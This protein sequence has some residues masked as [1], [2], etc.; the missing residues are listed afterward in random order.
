QT[1]RR[2]GLTMQEIES[3]KYFA[4]VESQTVFYFMEVAKL[5]VSRDPE[6]LTFFTMW[7]YEEYFHS[8]ALTPLLV[9]CGVKVESAT[10]RSLRIRAG[11]R[12]KAKLE[13][14]AQTLLAKF[15][16]RTFVGLWMFWGG[17]QECLTTQAY[18]EIARTTAN[19]VLAELCRR[20]AKQE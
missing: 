20:I 3:V 7:N 16:P 8:H 13:D 2:V 9:E 5:Q 14:L 19:P 10:E 1:A 4:D 15:M 11:A 18:E 17:L 12:W 6:L